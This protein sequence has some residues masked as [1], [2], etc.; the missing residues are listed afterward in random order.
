MKLVLITVL[1]VVVQDIVTVFGLQQDPSPIA[2]LGQTI[3]DTSVPDSNIDQDLTDRCVSC[4]SCS[5]CC[6]LCLWNTCEGICTDFK[7]EQNNYEGKISYVICPRGWSKSNIVLHRGDWIHYKTQRG[8][9]Y[10]GPVNCIVNFLRGE[11]CGRIKFSCSES[12]IFNKNPQYCNNGDRLT[13]S[14]GYLK[15]TFCGTRKPYLRGQFNA[16]L[17]TQF[18]ANRRDR[19]TGALC[20]AQCTHQSEALVQG[21]ASASADCATVFDVSNYGGN[22]LGIKTNSQYSNLL[23]IGWND[24]IASIEVSP[25]CQFTGWTHINF[26]GKLVTITSDQPILQ[27]SVNKRISSLKCTC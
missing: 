6:G 19:D 2:T 16:N 23:V 5:S 13:V 27:P 1:A 14:S 7:E 26:I 10:H 11:T 18:L 15:K 12:N 17:K 4:G 24:M 9:Y 22:S 21:Y 8:R 20:T 3:N 25:G